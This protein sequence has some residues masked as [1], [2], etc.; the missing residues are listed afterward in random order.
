LNIAIDSLTGRVTGL[1]AGTTGRVQVTDGSLASDLITL[2]VLP[3]ADT[4]EVPRDTIVVA[5]G[6]TTSPPLLA[7]VAA[8]DA[9][10]PTG[11]SGVSGRSVVFTIVEP[12]FADPAART[13][14]ITG[15]ALAD[16]VVTGTD[17]LPSAPVT[18]SRIA[19][20]TAPPIVLVEVK[21]VRRSGVLVPGSGQRFVVRFE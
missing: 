10:A 7:R 13:V 18:L 1:L 6:A 12:V 17:G 2:T 21:A 11:F 16:T 19:G 5:A 8:R 3:R 14:E 9:A 20:R 4:V 15:G